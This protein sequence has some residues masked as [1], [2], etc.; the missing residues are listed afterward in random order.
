MRLEYIADRNDYL[1]FQLFAASQS[2]STL[3]KIKKSRIVIAVIYAILSLILFLTEDTGLAIIFMGIAISW[4]LY[5][6]TYIRKRYKNQYEK[7]TDEYYHNRFG[8]SITIQFDD[9]YITCTDYSGEI[10]FKINEITGINEIA[11]FYFIKFSSGTYLIISKGRISQNEE[12]KVLLMQIASTLGIKFDI[13]L[14][15]KW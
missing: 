9:D 8:K 13:N 4:Y 14:A 7:Y 11:D 3:K 15:W 1:Q 6:P 10:K 5:Y 12:L 2:E